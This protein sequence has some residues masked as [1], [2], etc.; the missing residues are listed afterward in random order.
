MKI[1][2]VGIGRLGTAILA[3]NYQN[4]GIYHY[5]TKKAQ[6]FIKETEHIDLLSIEDLS[7]LDVCIFALPPQQIETLLTKLQEKETTTTFIN[8]ATALSTTSLREKFP[9]LHLIGVKYMGNAATLKTR[10]DGLFIAETELPKELV[11]F[12]EQAGRVVVDDET[13]V[14]HVNQTAT[15]IALQASLEM[16]QQLRS[17]DVK[18]AY[19]QEALQSVA[20]EVLRAYSRDEL[21]GFARAI[22]QQLT[23]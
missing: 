10:G 8:M 9:Q 17:E 19:I 22:L 18:Q 20:P 23:K 4:I 15:K 21:G 3:H 13:I 2:L 12:Y 1:G 6:Q 5:D 11:S 16:E 7:Q 14:Q